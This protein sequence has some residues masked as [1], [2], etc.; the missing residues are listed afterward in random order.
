MST[1]H[2][3]HQPPDDREIRLSIALVAVDDAIGEVNPKSFENEPALALYMR[4]G[5][6]TRLIVQLPESRA[7]L[8]EVVSCF[9]EVSADENEPSR[10]LSAD[11][12]RWIY[13][14]SRARSREYGMTPA[15]WLALRSE[16]LRPNVAP[17]TSYEFGSPDMYLGWMAHTQ[18]W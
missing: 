17:W 13:D 11:A 14:Q 4:R 16:R 6:D 2:E 5:T 9:S 10:T 8:V 12:I 18:H 3:S 15:E 7:H 1:S